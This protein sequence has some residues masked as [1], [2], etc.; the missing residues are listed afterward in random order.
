M[1]VRLT[2]AIKDSIK[3]NALAKA[4][5][6]KQKEE[7]KKEFNQLALDVRIEALGGEDKAKKTELVLEVA[8]AN[9]KMLEE[10]VSSNIYLHHTSGGQIYPAFGGQRTSLYYGKDKE[11]RDIRLLTP[12]KN[13][14]LFPSDHELSKRFE[15]LKQKENKLAEKETEIE[16]TT[17]AI[18]S[19]VT[20][21]KRLIE[22][23]PESKEL[24]PA[25]ISKSSATL[26]ALQVEDLN[27]LIGLPTD[28]K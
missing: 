6:F 19:S 16:T 1:T 20:T 23:W 28:K 8:L 3:N 12:S 14:C 11:N 25:D 5:I 7:L 24:I 10:E 13:K 26:P 9:V 17:R 2:N 21:I 18:L 4:G 27:K 15:K 22:I